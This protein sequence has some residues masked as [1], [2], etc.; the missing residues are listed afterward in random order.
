MRLLI[1]PKPAIPTETIRIDPIRVRVP[2][3]PLRVL[4]F[5]I[6]N[7]PLTYLGSDFTTAEVTAIAWAWTHAPDDVTCHLLGD[8]S[9]E[10]ILDEFVLAYNAA[11]MVTGHFIRCMTPET[12]VLTYDLQW[13]P[14]GD[15]RVG[16][17]LV[18]FDEHKVERSRKRLRTATVLSNRPRREPVY[19]VE[20]ATGEV[21]YATAEHP[22]LVGTR[23]AR[24]AQR[25]HWRRTDELMGADAKA[26]GRFAK[27]PV[28]LYR[29]LEPWNDRPTWEA[30]WLAGFFDGEG[31][32]GFC[33]SA[34]Q[35]LQ[36]T[37]TQN[38]G[39]T[40]EFAIRMLK[41]E[42]FSNAVSA[43]RS[44]LKRAHTIRINGGLNNFLRFLGQVRPE[45]LLRVWQAHGLTQSLQQIAM[46]RVMRVK[47]AGIREI[48]ALS[49][50]TRTYIAEGYAVHNSHDLPM[51]NGALLE[52]MRQPLGDKLC[53]DTKIDLLRAKGI[54][55]SQESLGAMFN[56]QSPKVQMNQGKWRA[57]N[58]L[59]PEGLREVR[60]RVVG[61]V[62]QHMELRAELL[63]RGYLGPARLWRSGA[64]KV[65]SYAP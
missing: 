60:E 44:P 58:R 51:I 29:V 16:E 48:S 55:R 14:V 46:V 17:K 11:D 42:G 9:L 8:E 24:R 62:R 13:K 18:G 40:L 31:T 19:A 21:L 56:L 12:R 61:D 41:H 34:G 53:S 22:W 15:L 26:P 35:A 64:S 39:G 6:E 36:L 20:L 25:F 5:D 27:E 23:P 2:S 50:S 30:G 54:S 4:D 1:R 33:G 43:R 32:L 47:P 49:T 37:A 38:P 10:F 65:E 57:A 52:L 3:R 59:T 45:R 28:L 63:R 7:R